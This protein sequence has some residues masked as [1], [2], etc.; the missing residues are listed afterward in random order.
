MGVHVTLERLPMPVLMRDVAKKAGVSVT[1]VSHVLNETRLVAPDT[2]DRVLKAISDLD[3]YANTSA[4]L[5]VRGQSDLVGLIISDIENPF[6]PELIKSFERASAGERLEVLL[7]AT[8]Y[9]RGHARNAVRRMLENRVRAVAVMTSQFDRELQ[10][11]LTS[12]N[13]PL[14]ALS[15][16]GA[17]RNRSI[18]DID[19]P[20]GIADAVRHL[21]RLGHRKIALATGPQ[22]QIS[23]IAHRESVVKALLRLG[24][25]PM[26]VLEGDHRPES[27]AEAAH[28]LLSGRDRPTAIFCGN[29]RMAIGAIGMARELGFRVPE[30]VSIIGSDDLWIARYSSPPLTTVRI[31][32]D[33]LGQLAFD[34]LMKMLRSKRRTG[35]REALKTELIIRASTARPATGDRVVRPTKQRAARRIDQHPETEL[36]G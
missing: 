12:K 22:D 17:D 31:P 18:I 13:V 3:Y 8:S 35:E 15:A 21:H 11:Q 1:T 30:D 5:L 10:A 19:W 27:G 25:K 29:D 2:R 23:A 6:F 33:T 9:D 20:S 4:R 16:D 28:I 32:R 24:A 26:R 36:A 34:V 14:V 7:C